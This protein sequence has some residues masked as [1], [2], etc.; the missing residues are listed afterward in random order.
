MNKAELI[1]SI[2]REWEALQAALDGLD[3]KQL[4]T[5]PVTG[6]W[7]VKD[8]LGHL[9][10]WESRLVTDLYKI[11]RGVEP[12]WKGLSDAQVDRLNAQFHQEQKSRPLERVLEDLHSVHLALLNRLDE[13]SDAALSSPDKYPITGG[14]SLA[15]VAMIDSA[16]HFQEHAAEIRSWRKGQRMGDE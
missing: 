2:E 16:E 1:A 11:Q 13:F 3:E 12:D 5:I 15:E 6:E 7:T 10:V 4:T 14:K 9:A 8:L